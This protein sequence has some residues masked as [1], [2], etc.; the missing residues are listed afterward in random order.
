VKFLFPVVRGVWVVLVEAVAI[1]GIW[2]A[3]CASGMG[4]F[5][6]LRWSEGE[7]LGRLEQGSGNGVRRLGC[8]QTI[9]TID[10]DG[11]RQAEA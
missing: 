7:L 1:E 5:V 3:G 2:H 9:N 10:N 11:K 6:F 8:T 4:S